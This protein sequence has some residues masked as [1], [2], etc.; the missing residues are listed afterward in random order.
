MDSQKAEERK[1]RHRERKKQRYAEEPELREKIEGRNRAH[2]LKKGDAINAERRHRYA[3]DPEYR[4]TCR[5]QG[6]KSQRKTSLKKKYGMSL[7]EYAAKLAGQGGICIICL[8][9]SERTLCVDHDHRNRKQRSLLCDKCNLG[10]G[11]FDDD[12]A[13]MR[14]AADYLDYWQWRHAAP[15]NT[16]PSPFALAAPNR[17]LAPTQQTIQYLEPEGEV[18]TPTKEPTDNNKASLMMRR[19]ILHELLQPFEPDLPPPV[20]ML[21]AVARAIVIEASQGDMTAAKE[22]LDR[23][24]G[25]TPPAAPELDQVPATRQV[26]VSWKSPI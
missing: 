13:V 24:D 9:A 20:D 22:V 16:G 7:E 14:Q 8:K 26:N 18:M 4:A 1:R 12:S 10:L 5:A 23:I 6:S 19:A 21:Q 3:T 25:K 17:F 11:Y 2:W 15:N